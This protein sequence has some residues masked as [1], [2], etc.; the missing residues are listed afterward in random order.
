MKNFATKLFH[1][2][3][4]IEVFIAVLVDLA[5]ASIQIQVIAGIIYICI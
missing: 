5:L 3:N 4:F 2:I 1:F